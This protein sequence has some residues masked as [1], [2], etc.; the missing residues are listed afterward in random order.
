[1]RR[2]GVRSVSYNRLPD[3]IKKTVNEIYW[4]KFGRQRKLLSITAGTSLLVLGAI[5]R[6]PALLEGGRDIVSGRFLPST[7]KGSLRNCYKRLQQ[8]VAESSHEQIRRLRE[9]TPDCR[10]KVDIFGNFLFQP[11]KRFIRKASEL[12]PRLAGAKV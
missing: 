8:E 6:T 5:T 11:R 2:A 9:S 10:V 3:N 1:V 7:K 12:A 4:I